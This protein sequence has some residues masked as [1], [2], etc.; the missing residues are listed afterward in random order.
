MHTMAINIAAVSVR[1]LNTGEIGTF[2]AFDMPVNI[3]GKLDRKTSTNLYT[4][5][6]HKN[7]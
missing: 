3:S 5:K 1:A 6:M 4:V 2:N 7:K